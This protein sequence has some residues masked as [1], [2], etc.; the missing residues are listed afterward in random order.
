MGGD[1]APLKALGI[2]HLADVPRHHVEV[3]KE[4]KDALK[5]APARTSDEDPL[6]INWVPEAKG[7]PGRF[8]ATIF[9]GKKQKEGRTDGWN[10]NLFQDLKQIRHTEKAD[11]LVPLV[12]GWE[13][14]WLG[15]DV[16][17]PMAESMGLKVMWYPVEDGHIPQGPNLYL[18][19]VERVLFEAQK[20]KKI[21]VHCRGGIGRTG[22]LIA[23][24][25]VAHGIPP[26]PAILKVRE[27]RPNAVENP[28]QILFVFEFAE[29]W[30]KQMETRAA[31][32]AAAAKVV[33]APMTPPAETAHA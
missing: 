31:K 13:F 29:L 15:V 11:V 3:T 27:A 17:V 6:I 18:N 28:R 23:C 32:K 10:R 4:E 5:N 9:P 12:E 14:K 19:F 7:V 25:L 8:G 26:E 20:G 30:K 22:T 21:V 2:E 1:D 24:C 33:S 16:L